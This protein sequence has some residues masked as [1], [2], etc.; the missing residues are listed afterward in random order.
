MAI[1]RP[2]DDLASTEGYFKLDADSG[3]ARERIEVM[4]IG[5]VSPDFR[6]ILKPFF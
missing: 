2:G 3:H 1:T 5:D 6:S 4:A